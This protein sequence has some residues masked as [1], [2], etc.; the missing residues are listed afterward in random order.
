MNALSEANCAGHDVA[1]RLQPPA[2]AAAAL[3]QVCSPQP[4]PLAASPAASTVAVFDGV[5]VRIEGLHAAPEMNGRTGVVSG[6]LDCS[7]RW[8]VNVYAHGAKPACVG[9][10]KPAN[11]VVLPSL[12]FST[13][14]LGEDGC[15]YP[16]NVA[17]SS[18]CPKGHA[19]VRLSDLGA[20][21][22][23]PIL[24]CR[25]CHAFCERQSYDFASWSICSVVDNCCGGYSVCSCCAQT[26]VAAEA[27]HAC[28]GDDSN[29]LVS[30]AVDSLQLP[31]KL[32]LYGTGRRAAVL[33][34]AQ[35]NSAL[36]IWPHH[37]ISILSDVRATIHMAETL[38]LQRAANGAR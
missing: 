3:N 17:F 30:R 31:P 7:G 34:V 4:L 38:Q 33:V 26:S 13:E 19:L 21:R 11:L 18:H 25:L 20:T 32:M 27:D 14:W 29:T 1:A 2:Q 23:G 12:N 16:K 5:R 9:T 37:H 10:F 36:F 35:L 6:A 8:R 28:T 24:M 22:A 15:V